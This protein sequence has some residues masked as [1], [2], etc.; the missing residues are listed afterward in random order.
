MTTEDATRVAACAAGRSSGG[1]GRGEH[2]GEP[3]DHVA[4]VVQP[5]RGSRLASSVRSA[6][7]TSMVS[8]CRTNWECV[9]ARCRLRALALVTLRA[10]ST[11]P[12]A[13]WWRSMSGAGAHLKLGATT[14]ELH[15]DLG[16]AAIG[17]GD[18]VAEHLLGRHP[19]SVVGV[20][21]FMARSRSISAGF[22]SRTRPFGLMT[23]TT[24]VI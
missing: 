22:R 16:L 12:R 1:A 14:E 10:T 24:S 17:R 19:T 23:T 5:V 13:R 18:H 7:S 15:H 6:R 8:T 20:P 3:F 21:G 4:P 11:V 9:V 2:R